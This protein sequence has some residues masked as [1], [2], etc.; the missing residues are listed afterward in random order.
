MFVSL[1]PV[2]VEKRGINLLGPASK[3]LE[4]ITL[5]DPNLAGY[6]HRWGMLKIPTKE[7]KM[8]YYPAIGLGY[9]EISRGC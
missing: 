9:T 4:G 1:N 3:A 6:P 5:Y 2:G 8:S 7:L